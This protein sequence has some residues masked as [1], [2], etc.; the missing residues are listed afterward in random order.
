MNIRPYKK[1]LVTIVEGKI[2][3]IVYIK[4]FYARRNANFDEFVEEKLYIIFI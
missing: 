4:Y 2:C 1:Y 3:K